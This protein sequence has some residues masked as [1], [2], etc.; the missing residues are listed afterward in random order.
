MNDINVGGEA[1]I[2]GG[3]HS[4][5]HDVHNTTNTTNHVNTTTTTTTNNVVNNST[6][7]QAQRTDA[8]FKLDNE[9]QFLKAVQERFADGRLDQK[10][11]AE[12]SQLCI[13]WN[14]PQE[15]ANEIINQVRTSINILMG[16]QGNDYL[17]NQM[18]QEVFNA[19]QSNAAEVLRHK[20]NAFERLV[21]NSQNAI[22]K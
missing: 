14:V 4:D 22:S 19:V 21:A 8:E 11:L 6:V 2:M 17:V 10:E 7:Y 12:L 15:R 1:A 3:V 16:D 9:N 20:M 18:L 5:S 13:Q